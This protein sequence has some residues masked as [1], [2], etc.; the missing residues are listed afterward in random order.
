MGSYMDTE[1]FVL[2]CKNASE[3]GTTDEMWQLGDD[4][5]ASGMALAVF[6]ILI[7]SVGLPWNLMVIVTIIKEKLY[8]QPT[9]VLLLNLVCVDLFFMITLLPINIVTGIAGEFILGNNDLTR[10]NSCKIGIL[11]PI[12]PILLIYA[13][14]FLSFDRFFYFYKPLQYKRIITI[15]RTLA[16]IFVKWLLV[17]AIFIIIPLIRIHDSVI[18]YRPFAA[19]TL[20]ISSIVTFLVTLIVICLPLIVLIV[21]NVWVIYIVQKT[22]RKVYSFR[23]T[24]NRNDHDVDF[25]KR[26]KQIRQ[27]KQFHLIKV[28]GGLI[29]SFLIQWLPMVVLVILFIP[30][31]SEVSIAFQ[32]IVLVLFQAQVATHPILESTLIRDVRK[33]LMKILCCCF[34]SRRLCNVSSIKNC[35]QSDSD[36]C[37][38][39][40]ITILEVFFAVT[41]ENTNVSSTDDH[42]NDTTT[43]TPTLYELEN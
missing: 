15:P 7:L 25:D 43:N 10:C 42:Q 18:F 24:A 13:L 26:V 34:F 39:H 27:K 11:D 40:T 20:N 38:K 17:F 31:G 29:L 32:V 2:F 28:F 22:I 4:Y 9:I 6:Q 30:Q 5:R 36:N 8:K 19:C 3:N 37:C 14:T 12:F 23:I 41:S 1:G 33:P 21:L 35:C 16:V